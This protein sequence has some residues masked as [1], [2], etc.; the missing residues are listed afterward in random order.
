M[1][2][3]GPA[4]GARKYTVVLA[5]DVAAL[6]RLVRI[7]TEASG[8]FQVVGEATTGLEAIE[9]AR[10][11][12]PDLVLLDLS[13]PEL[14]GLE[15][16]PRVLEASPNS[17]VV[18]LS[19]FNHVRMEPVAKRMG[20][21]AYLE[22]GLEP[23][24]LVQALLDV[25]EPR[26]GARPTHPSGPQAAMPGA[27][28]PASFPIP[29][30]AS[31]PRGPPEAMASAP[32]SF[33]VLLVEAD[34]GTAD[35]LTGLMSATRVARF[36]CSHAATLEAAAIR[37][38]GTEADIVL[39][40]PSIATSPDEA[41]IEVLGRAAGVPVVALA[42]PTDAE[43]AARALRLGIEDCI[44][45]AVQDADNLG[46]SL[47]YALERRRAQDAR[48][49]LRDQA[50]QL[51]HVLD[52]QALRTQFFNAA[53][54]E[55]GN[56]LTPIRLQ[57]SMLK[58][59]T[60]GLDPA[61]QRSLEILER[62][63]Q[64]MARLNQDMLDVARLQAR[65]LSLTRRPVEVKALIREAVDAFEP[66]AR[67]SGIGLTATCPDGI[68]VDADGQRL[69][70]VLSNLAGNA[71]KFTPHG[72]LVA[73]D[74]RAEAHEVHVSVRDTGPG[75]SPEQID[76]LFQ[77]FSQVLGTAQPH[78]VGAGLGLFISRGIVELHGGRITCQSAGPGMGCTFM[79]ILP[80]LPS[81]AVPAAMQSV[82][83]AA[84]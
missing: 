21:S 37:L 78:G 22:K 33:R 68:L 80:R 75:L 49:L 32:R 63:V 51:Q 31:P 54:H 29:D 6:R 79:F 38:E 45:P 20:A 50:G 40:D 2:L 25:L 44:D 74:V 81:A 58:D 3:T 77:P 84:S 35:R 64:R 28:S 56:P 62:N 53:A 5:D 26:G 61:V 60:R 42:A 69:M 13:M 10:E 4:P 72:G 12:R 43:L 48:R 11:L 16:L 41:F 36:V 55:L 65:S 66:L 73:L 46:R 17:H 18:V 27:S 1:T 67:E 7:S 15:A 19:G 47:L 30:L 34:A 83:V 70:Q 59:L 76:R 52:L 39:L 9:R 71:L 24:G 57:V 8:R 14:D 23:Q 82:A